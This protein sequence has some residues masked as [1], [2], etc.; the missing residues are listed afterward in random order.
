PGINSF[1]Q[2][3]ND[4]TAPFH[5][6]KDGEDYWNS[7]SALNFLDGVRMPTLLIS[8]GNDPFCPDEVIPK[9]VIG[10]SKWLEGDFHSSGGHVGFVSGTWPWAPHYWAEQR[11]LA[12]LRE[13]LI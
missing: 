8:A 3:D 12:Y 11:A 7:C 5:G 10:Q 13:H 6:F 4:V 1:A 9:R 2:F